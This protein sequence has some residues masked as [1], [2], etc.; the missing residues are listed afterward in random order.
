[1]ER[2]TAEDRFFEAFMMGLRLRDG[3]S[4]SHVENVCGLRFEN[5]VDQHHLDIALGQGWV[6]YDGDR[7]SLTREGMLRLNAL[8]SYLIA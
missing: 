4:V 5:M 8:L 7:I 1:M 3:I 2:L 6:R